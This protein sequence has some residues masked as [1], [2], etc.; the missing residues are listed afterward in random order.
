MFLYSFKSKNCLIQHVSIVGNTITFYFNKPED[1]DSPEFSVLE[2]QFNMKVIKGDDDEHLVLHNPNSPIF[3]TKS[4]HGHYSF[5]GQPATMIPKI[6]LFLLEYQSNPDAREADY[7]TYVKAVDKVRISAGDKELPS[8]IQVKIDNFDLKTAF[9]PSDETD[10]L[11]KSFSTYL[12]PLNPTRMFD[13]V[14]DFLL[15]LLTNAKK[16]TRISNGGDIFYSNVKYDR[17]QDNYLRN[18]FN[19]LKKCNDLRLKYDINK[20][21]DCLAQAKALYFE[22]EIMHAAQPFIDKLAAYIDRIE[23]YKA[24]GKTDFSSGFWFFA[25]SRAVNRQANYLLAK[26]MLKELL[27]NV[28]VIDVFRDVDAMRNDIIKINQLNNNP[29]FVERGLNSSELNA[30]FSDAKL[31]TYHPPF[32]K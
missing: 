27:D 30:I 6:V 2:S 31:R 16:M 10:D 5:T 11:L 28:P 1:H 19:I 20:E 14:V 22:I 25:G 9:V 21:E 13:K 8:R 23:S 32:H 29:D 7:N 12:S 4:P 24:N 18:Y 15:A 3:S 17:I 26:K